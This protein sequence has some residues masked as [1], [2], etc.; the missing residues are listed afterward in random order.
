[1]VVFLVDLPCFLSDV[2]FNIL[3]GLY[4]ILIFNFHYFEKYFFPQLIVQFSEILF[5]ETADQT[6]LYEDH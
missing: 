5:I 4:T 1:M 3:S 2:Q 6:V